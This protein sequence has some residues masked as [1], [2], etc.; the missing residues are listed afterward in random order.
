MFLYNTE[1]FLC[2]EV[3]ECIGS[4]FEFVSIYVF[5][6]VGLDEITSIRAT[7]LERKEDWT[8]KKIESAKKY[9]EI[10]N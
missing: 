6:L 3:Q 1:P 7:K 10:A 5:Y 9:Y 8:R 2:S 4:R